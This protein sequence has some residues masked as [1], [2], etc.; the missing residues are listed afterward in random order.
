M[1]LENLAKFILHVGR[2]TPLQTISEVVEAINRF[3]KL[4]LLTHPQVRLQGYN[5]WDC[6]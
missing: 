6:G 2:S 5:F 4:G 1:V 3:L